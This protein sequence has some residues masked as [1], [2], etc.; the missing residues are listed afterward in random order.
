MTYQKGWPI[1]E[2]KLVQRERWPGRYGVKY[3]PLVYPEQKVSSDQPVLRLENTQTLKYSTG[4]PLPLTE[5]VPAGLTGRVV[6]ITPRGGVIIESRAMLVRGTIGV[7]SQVAGVLTL[8]PPDGSGRT[9]LS[10]GSLLVVPGPTNFAFLHQALVSGVSAVIAS[11]IVARDLEG[12]LRTDIIQL[13]DC[14]D[15]ETAQVHLPP[16]TLFLTE[17]L[18][19]FAMPAQVLNLFNYYQGT[20]ALLSAETSPRRGIFPELA[21][22][23][24]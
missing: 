20:V 2:Q 9:P 17:G 21:L 24:L 5:S 8:W 1:I 18:G 12:F 6:K 4:G 14:D 13:L 19:T 10:P 7:G 11:S 23:A 3:I 16:V 22:S 15:I